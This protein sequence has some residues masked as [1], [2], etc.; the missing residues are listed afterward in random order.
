[1]ESLLAL[2]SNKKVSDEG[3]NA[4]YSVASG[5]RDPNQMLD[6][7]DRWEPTERGAGSAFR[8]LM[9]SVA[10]VDPSRTLEW[11]KA[12]TPAA[13]TADRL[14]QIL[15]G[16]QV[17]AQYGTS[18][19]T[20]EDV[21][22]FYQ[23]GFLSKNATDEIKRVFA[24]A[25]GWA[26]E[27]DAALGREI[28]RRIF[29]SRNKSF[30]NAA[31]GSLRSVGS[32][33]LAAEICQLTREFAAR[34]Q[35]QATFGHFLEVMS[36]RNFEVRSAL[37][38]ALAV[39]ESRD[40]IKHLNAPVVVSHLLTLLKSTV[41]ADVALVLD[42]ASLC[43]R[44]DE[45]NDAAL[46][47]VLENA[48]RQTDD[49]D[50]SRKIL[51]WLLELASVASYRVRNSLRRALPRLDE[52]LPHREVADTALKTILASQ[53]WSEKAQEHL[54]RAASKVN[55]WSREDTETVLRSDLSHVV[56]AVL[57]NH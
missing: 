50:L 22:L 16:F 32:P 38:Q 37:L 29:K 26:A 13:T 36:G 11:L 24:G 6:V 18:A 5:S 20:A 33:E 23:L 48:C 7:L 43:P 15:V 12:R 25:A 17:V 53:H 54:V 40:F 46:S 55:S 44:L 34:Q 49:L 51:R 57:L 21:R 35:G 31:I 41:K 52:V 47:A 42:L 27:V 56:K 14:R 9:E 1:M 4:I 39:P 8:I 2:P 28:Y 30:I 19:V 10:K 3:I 45:G